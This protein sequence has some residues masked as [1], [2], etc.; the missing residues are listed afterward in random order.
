MRNLFFHLM[1]KMTRSFYISEKNF[2]ETIARQGAT[3]RFI[4]WNGW[5]AYWTVLFVF[6]LLLLLFNKTYG[7]RNQFTCIYCEFVERLQHQLQ[8]E[9]H[10]F[11]VYW[12]KKTSM[13]SNITCHIAHVCVFLRP[14]MWCGISATDSVTMNFLQSFIFPDSFG[15]SLV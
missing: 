9:V 14:H 12:W 5:G 10:S 13:K 2:H 15:V 7:I 3:I 6:R 11:V 4:Y 1:L 8:G